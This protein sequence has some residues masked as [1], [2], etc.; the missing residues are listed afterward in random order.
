M[1]P[2]IRKT[3]K[4][5]V[6]MV[7]VCVF[8]CIFSASAEKLFTDAD[9]K[10]VWVVENYTD[11][12]MTDEEKALALHDWL[13]LNAYYDTTM[14]APNSHEA[15]GVLLDGTGVCDSYSKAYMLLLSKAGIESKR[16]TGNAVTSEGKLEPHAWNLVKLAGKWYQ[17]D[18]TWD[19][20]VDPNHLTEKVSGLEHRL[21]FKASKRFMNEE[22]RPDPESAALIDQL[23]EDDAASEETPP[24]GV[25]HSKSYDLPQVHLI[26]SSG[27]SITG[28]TMR[29]KDMILVYGRI[30]CVNTRAF[31]SNISPFM[32]LLKRRNV[33]VTVALY[34]D[35]SGNEMREF[36][37]MYPGIVCTKVA[38]DD[39]SMW[40]GLDAFGNGGTSVVFPVIFLKNRNV[41]NRTA[42]PSGDV[43]T[44][45][46]CIFR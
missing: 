35:P 44:V 13:V 46:R 26:S 34:D 45:R 27:A 21:Y 30:A 15:A 36:A 39:Y 14:A 5:I 25:D 22:H 23:V 38:T 12:S 33:Q 8:L 32:D 6:I 37:E 16:V 3:A 11:S 4:K 2:S 7:L 43:Y 18:V 29:G 20:P 28:E 9:S 1:C 40:E 17:V 41:T 31:L 42:K 10:A 19:D 24:A